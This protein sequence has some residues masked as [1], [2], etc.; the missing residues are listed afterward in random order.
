MSSSSHSNPERTRLK[1]ANRAYHRDIHRAD[2]KYKLVT[3]VAKEIVLNEHDETRGKIVLRDFK[4]AVIFIINIIVN[5][6][7]EEKRGTSRKTSVR[8]LLGEGRE[9]KGG[10]KRRDKGNIEITNL[11]GFYSPV[12]PFSALVSRWF[13]D[14]Y[15]GEEED[16]GVHVVF[17]RRR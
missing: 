17:C 11:T 9:K 6:K 16:R 15:R 4:R 12:F 7:R 2:I 3:S 10:A 14:A 1:T 8:W 5:R 13:R